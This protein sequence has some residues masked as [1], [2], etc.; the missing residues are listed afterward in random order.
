LRRAMRSEGQ[1]GADGA[2]ADAIPRGREGLRA[3]ARTLGGT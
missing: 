2:L 3:L 1:S